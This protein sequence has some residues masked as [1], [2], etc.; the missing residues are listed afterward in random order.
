MRK[1]A[2]AL[3]FLAG[4]A[5]AGC[6]TD[7]FNPQ[8]KVQVITTKSYPEIPD[9]EPVAP[10]N[11]IPWQYDIPRDTSRIVPKNTTECEKVPEEKR[12]DAYWKKC[13]ENPP[14]KNTNLYIG[15]DHDNWNIFL[16]DWQK[17]QEK[18]L[19]YKARIEEINKQRKE[20][21]DL[22]DQERKKAKEKL[23]SGN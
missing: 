18:N 22:A 10:V 13:W 16:E 21:R 3:M 1:I 17:L 7:G 2:L 6:A 20:W 4:S 8:S 5:L 14:L 19:Q 11:L 15:F 12:D 23:E 9:I